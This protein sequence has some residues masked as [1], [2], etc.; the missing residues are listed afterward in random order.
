L[1]SNYIGDTDLGG[2]CVEQLPPMRSSSQS[3]VPVN[4]PYRWTAAIGLA[5]AIGVSAGCVDQKV[6][7]ANA[8]SLRIGVGTRGG[9]F[10]GLG[11]ALAETLR[12]G[13]PGYA[14]EI[15]SNEGAV[16]TLESLQR[17]T[18]D[19]GFSYA[20]V[21]Y[22]AFAGRLSDEPGPLTHLRGVALLQVSPLY[23]LARRGS[24]IQSVRDLRGRTLAFGGR[25]SASSRAALLVL[26]AAGLDLA[27]VR[28]QNEGF[29]AS[30]QRLR[31]GTLDAVFVLAGQPSHFIAKAASHDARL[32]P[33]Q[34][35]VMDGLRERYPFL[36]PLLIPARTYSQ[37]VAPIKTVGIAS[38]LLCRDD[39]AVEHVYR[40]TQDWFR[41]FARLAKEGQVADGVG[42]PL[43]SAT[44][45][46][47]HPGASDY[48]RAR[49]VRLR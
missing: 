19:C 28:I 5:F 11:R 26:N 48:Y 34:G 15:V 25:G 43:A 44:P 3:M 31:A 29:P 41:T 6:A 32:L 14:V 47:L 17:G 12:S 7:A 9:D 20:N 37:Q 39:V 22:E 42:A 21:A 13:K 30:F 24:S 40:V 35:P 38:V 2:G 46:P 23:F 18:S 8:P 27:S 33:L 36:R 49:Q 45:I 16:S 10:D 4:R 1:A